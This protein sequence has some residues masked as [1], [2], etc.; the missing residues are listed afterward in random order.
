MALHGLYLDLI[1]LQ[2]CEVDIAEPRCTGLVTV[3]PVNHDRKA[4]QL[5]DGLIEGCGKVFCN[6]SPLADPFTDVSVA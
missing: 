3:I 5:G 1:S 2:A 6:I 4:A